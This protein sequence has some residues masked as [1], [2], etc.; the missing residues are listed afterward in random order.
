M[1]FCY[2]MPYFNALLIRQAHMVW[3]SFHLRS[4]NPFM[5]RSPK[6][7]FDW[8]INRVV[9]FNIFSK[10]SNQPGW[11]EF[12]WWV[13]VC[14]CGKVEACECSSIMVAIAT[15][16]HPKNTIVIISTSVKRGKS[17][18]W[19]DVHMEHTD[20]PCTA[21]KTNLLIQRKIQR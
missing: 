8:N 21:T 10:P 12:L 20:V 17:V 15:S 6:S 3:D 18:T 4:Y 2:I 1:F 9:K 11:N 19:S 5:L 14:C 13:H 7:N 16:H